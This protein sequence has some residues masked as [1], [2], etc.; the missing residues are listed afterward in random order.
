[1][2]KILAF[3][4]LWTCTQLD[5][6]FVINQNAYASGNE[7][8]VLTD[9]QTFQVGTIWNQQQVDLTQ[10]F[11]IDFRLNFGTIDANGADGIAFSIQQVSTSVG[12]AGGGIGYENI[13]PSITVEF[14]TW[15][16]TDRNDPSYDHVSI[17]QDGDLDHNSSNN[18]SG[19]VQIDPTNIN[20]ED[21]LWKEVSIEWNADSNKLTV[22]YDCKEQISYKGDIIKDIFG[23]DPM[24][25]WGFTSATGGSVN[26]QQVCVT[27]QTLNQNQDGLG[28]SDTVVLNGPSGAVSYQWYPDVYMSDD[29]IEDPSVYPLDTT[30]YYLDYVDRCGKS[31]TDSINVNVTTI[32]PVDLPND[33]TI[34]EE[35]PLKLD[36]INSPLA[37]Y[38]W[39]H[40]STD[41]VIYVSDSGLYKVV[42]TV[43]EC[44]DSGSVNVQLKRCK[45]WVPNIFTPNGDGINDYFEVVNFEEADRLHIKIYNRW[46]RK[47]YEDDNYQNNWNGTIKGDGR[48]VAAG[49]YYYVIF[50]EGADH[51]TYN[52]FITLT[53]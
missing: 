14:D 3:L 26:K 7:C 50:A 21:G 20:V 1:M 15:Q 13:K 16:N 48:A 33:T 23:N 17:M 8:Y 9:P 29:T 19:P 46:G 36:V 51:D 44:S 24:A 28:C 39:D 32:L 34:C 10:S 11:K 37:T 12:V 45:I 2:K 41:S 40:G 25:F 42:V 22:L 27:I 35:V 43:G 47:V 52:G 4:L 49:V 5:A 38:E 30:K 31:W 18:L 53:R 6:Q